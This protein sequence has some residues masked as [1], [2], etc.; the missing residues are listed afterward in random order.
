MSDTKPDFSAFVCYTTYRSVPMHIVVL[1]SEQCVTKTYDVPAG[2]QLET[3]L[4]SLFPTAKRLFLYEGGMIKV[5]I[6]DAN[7]Q[8][9]ETHVGFHRAT[10]Q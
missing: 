9:I 10:D 3:Y 8:T 1:N 6:V 2:F 5:S 4:A 7:G